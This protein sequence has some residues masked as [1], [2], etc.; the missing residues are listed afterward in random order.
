[1]LGRRRPTA[2]IAVS[3]APAQQADGVVFPALVPTTAAAAST[4][5]AAI[6]DAILD[7]ALHLSNPS[8]PSSVAHRQKPYVL[9]FGEPLGAPVGRV[10]WRRGGRDEAGP[11]GH[12]SEMP[13]PVC[14][15]CRGRRTPPWTS[16]PDRLALVPFSRSTS[17]PLLSPQVRP[18]FGGLGFRGR[19]VFA[20][21]SRPGPLGL[22]VRPRPRFAA[23]VRPT[24]RRRRRPANL[25]LPLSQ[26][27]PSSP[28][29][30]TNPS[31]PKA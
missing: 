20:R 25:H 10:V 17:R 9:S 13:P 5:S 6:L 23:L 4:F 2:L 29:L 21:L 31:E 3:R 27:R 18:W 8:L 22:T 7:N 14:G 12:S 19:D 26:P 24:H 11:E 15:C 16:N 30:P 1:M 28:P